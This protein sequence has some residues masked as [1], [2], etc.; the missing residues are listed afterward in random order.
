MSKE[1]KQ[2]KKARQQYLSNLIVEY[3]QLQAGYPPFSDEWTKLNKLIA[4][5]QQELLNLEQ[6]KGLGIRWGVVIESLIAAAGTATVSGLILKH[7]RDG[8][9]TP[10]FMRDITSSTFRKTGK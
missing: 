10:N 9:M 4:M 1:M 3:T 6:D 7:E 2:A 5:S 8:Y